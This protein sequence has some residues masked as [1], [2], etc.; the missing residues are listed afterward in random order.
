MI[1]IP[2]AGRSSRFRN[3]GYNTVKYMLP[4]FEQ[5]VFYYS[6][7]SFEK[8]FESETFVFVALKSDNVATFIAQNCKSLGIKK[9][10]VLELDDVTKGQAETVKYAL[11]NKELDDHLVI[12]NIDTFRP[13]F[14]LPSSTFLSNCDGYLETF[15]GEGANWSNIVPLNKEQQTV[16]L[17]AEKQSISEYCCSGIYYFAS[18]EIYLSTYEEYFK[19]KANTNSEYFIA[20]MYNY[21]I[22][23]GGVVKYSVIQKEDVIFCGVPE[24]YVT[25]LNDVHIVADAYKKTKEK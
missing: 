12:F 24:E 4:L 20:P 10:E 21:I 5:T 6:L 9:F 8:Y 2:M 18:V 25:L 3:A 7:K 11:Q 13:N 22:S 23:E 19:T 16:S 1:V 14:H 17:T 15:I